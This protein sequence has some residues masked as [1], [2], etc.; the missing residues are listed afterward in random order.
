[1]DLTRRSFLG[2]MGKTLGAI[3]VG[4]LIPDIVKASSERIYLP[5][6][7]AVNLREPI[8][9]GGNFNWG[10]ATKNGERIPQDDKTTRAIVNSAEYMQKIRGYLGDRPIT[11]TSWY[12]DLATNR[13]IG[14]SDTSRHVV[15]DAV[16]FSVSGLSPNEV[17]SRL[18]SYHGNMGGLARSQARGFTHLDLRGKKARWDY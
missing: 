9:S 7:G 13:E 3:V 1:M 18:D 12:R 10:E 11:V 8:I 4:T 15:G 14:S 6:K 16:D 2:M 5:G 17:Y